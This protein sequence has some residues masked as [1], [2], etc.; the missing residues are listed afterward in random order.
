[1]STDR[2][3]WRIP[4]ALLQDGVGSDRG[5]HADDCVVRVGTGFALAGSLAA[6]DALLWVFSTTDFL[7]IVNRVSDVSY[8]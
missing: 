4:R 3:Y 2:Y 5:G 8:A 1:M 7:G 6:M